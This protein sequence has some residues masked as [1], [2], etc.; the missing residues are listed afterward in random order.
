MIHT[1]V[2]FLYNVHS[3]LFGYFAPYARARARRCAGE[4]ER[5][6]VRKKLRPC[7]R[8]NTI[9]SSACRTPLASPARGPPH[10]GT[11]TPSV[12]YGLPSR[13]R[14]P[15]EALR[16]ILRRFQPLVST[17]HWSGSS[18]PS[19]WLTA[20]QGPLTCTQHVEARQDTRCGVAKQPL[21]PVSSGPRGLRS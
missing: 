19:D 12:S 1:R 20:P 10:P 11:G 3:S 17:R 2:F 15:S 8:L 18:D 5:A 13:P 4:P 6:S 7:R 9:E 14:Y 21:S 16:A